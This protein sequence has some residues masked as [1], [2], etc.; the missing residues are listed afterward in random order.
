M[1]AVD[2]IDDFIAALPGETRK[3][4]PGEWGI[5]VAP[6]QAAGRGLDV[7][8]RLTEGILRA[9]A[10]ALDSPDEV[11]PWMLLWWN[12]QTRHVRFA[13]TEA[14]E[15][16]VHGDLPVAAVDEVGLDRLLG[17]VVE[18]AVAVR[19]YQEAARSRSRSAR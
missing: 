10:H 6:E 5:R 17:L 3:L 8:L 14:K 2:L 15:V 19:E 4:A 7:G 13:C 11:D 16:W 12:R 18:G 1:A 9:R